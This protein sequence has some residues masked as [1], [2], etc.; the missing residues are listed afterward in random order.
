M[1]ADLTRGGIHNH[2]SVSCRCRAL[3]DS[4]N[5]DTAGRGTETAFVC[6]DVIALLEAR[7]THPLPGTETTFECRDVIALPNVY[8]LSTYRDLI[9]LITEVRLNVLDCYH[10]ISHTTVPQIKMYN[11]FST[12]NLI[13]GYKLFCVPLQAHSCC[14]V[15]ARPAPD[16]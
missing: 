16:A 5:Q 10:E 13:D 8:S 1:T 2:V 14:S 12:S 11:K 6:R 3:Y 7:K 4:K 9:G 15:R